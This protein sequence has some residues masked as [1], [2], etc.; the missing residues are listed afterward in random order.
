MNKFFDGGNLDI[1]RRFIRDETVDLFLISRRQ[2]PGA[3]N[4]IYKNHKPKDGARGASV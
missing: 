3:K 1:P 2:I 4:Q